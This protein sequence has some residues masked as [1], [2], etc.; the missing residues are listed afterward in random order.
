MSIFQPVSWD[1]RRTFWPFLPMASDSL[2][3]GT[4]SSI[5]CVSASMST[6]DTS[7][8]AIA[9]HTKRAGSGSHG[10]MSIFSPRSSCTTAWTRE[11]LM[12]TQAPTGSTSASR[13]VRAIFEREPGSRATPP[14]V[15]AVHGNLRAGA[16]L[17]RDAHDL[18]DALVDFRHF[19]LE[20]L[21]HEVRR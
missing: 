2:S 19:R 1:A 15:G 6:R 21:F 5:V 18:H 3:S 12:P 13:L 17:A 9:L 16:G 7:A 4:I 11:P 20:Q 8:G 10:T 14:R